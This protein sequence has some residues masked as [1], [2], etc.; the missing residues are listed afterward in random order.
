[1][2]SIYEVSGDRIIIL[3]S[4]L[5][6]MDLAMK[7]IYFSLGRKS[8]IM[9][10]TSSMMDPQIGD[11]VFRKPSAQAKIEFSL[12]QCAEDWS[13]NFKTWLLK[14]FTCSVV[15]D[16]QF[17]HS[18]DAPKMMRCIMLFV[19]VP[20]Q[21]F[22]EAP[23]GGIMTP[24]IPPS[25]STTFHRLSQVGFFPDGNSVTLC[26]AQPFP[27]DPVTFL[28]VDFWRDTYRQE[29]YS[30]LQV[31]N[32]VDNPSTQCPTLRMISLWKRNGERWI[33]DSSVI[34]PSLQSVSEVAKEVPV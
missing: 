6:P 28:R 3:S 1:M 20:S 2:I 14:V 22:Q 26:F 23:S 4:S 9:L 5:M 7:P 13:Q 10:D 8:R 31:L 33:C 21:G 25:E 27:P 11:I 34:G 17:L 12:Y 15:F 24:H 32:V 29:A 18:V 16:D 30:G 19:W